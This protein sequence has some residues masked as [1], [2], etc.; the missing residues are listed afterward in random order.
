VCYVEICA[1]ARS[2]VRGGNADC[3]A[4]EC[5]HEALIMRMPW[6]TGDF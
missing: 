2:R 3:G 6:L 1:T 4:S 5:D